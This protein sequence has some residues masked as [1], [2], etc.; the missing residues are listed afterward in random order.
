MPVEAVL[1]NQKGKEKERERERQG[2]LVVLQTHTHTYTVGSREHNLPSTSRR[3]H[4]HT[5]S[6][7]VWTEGKEKGESTSVS[8]GPNYTVT[9]SP[10][11]LL[12]FSHLLVSRLAFKFFQRR[13]HKRG[14]NKKKKKKKM[15]E[16]QLRRETMLRQNSAHTD[17]KDKG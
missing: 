12:V 13:I 3:E 16:C 14:K 11:F 5:H 1:C 10:P 8:S 7:E 6:S 2:H 4:T 17:G 15:K 9:P